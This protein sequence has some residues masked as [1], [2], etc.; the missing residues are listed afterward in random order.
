MNKLIIALT[1]F[2]S[3]AA[4]SCN[5]DN[6]PN[7]PANSITMNMMISDGETTI[8]G[9]DVYISNSVNFTT[10]QCGIADL[11]KKEEWTKVRICRRS[12]RR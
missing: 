2:L 3:I 4:V 1:V 11:G 6:E 8:G 10:S 9:S 7:L 5:D 12:G